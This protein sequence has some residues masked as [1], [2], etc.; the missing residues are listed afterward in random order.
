MRS[1]ERTVRPCGDV[2]V[3]AGRAPTQ[4]GWYRFAAQFV[5][6]KSTLDVG[7][8]LGQGLPVLREQAALVHGQ[9][10]DPRLAGTGI[11]VRDLG[12]FQEKSYDVVVAVD[13]LEHVADARSFLRQCVRVARDGL[14]ITT[15]NWTSSRCRWP[16]H[17]REY[18]PIEFER[19]LLTFGRVALFK[20]NCSGDRVNPV[21]WRHAY[22]LLNLLRNVAETAPLARCMNRV[23]PRSCRIGDTSAAYVSL[24]A[25][26]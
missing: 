15:P 24:E 3:A 14:F 21:R 17:Y 18:T 23:L 9:D 12:A 7:C 5:R 25:N 6:G 26:E 11:F 20:G 8:G 19:L 2:G 1:P 10:L 13:I 4:Q 16:Y 22:H